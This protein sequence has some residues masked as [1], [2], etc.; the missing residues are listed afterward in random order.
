MT[1]IWTIYLSKYTPGNIDATEFLEAALAR[2]PWEKIFEDVEGRFY[3]HSM[4]FSHCLATTNP[5]TLL[6]KRL[7]IKSFKRLR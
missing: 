2:M 7:L 3:Q 6:N 4:Y 5:E 1:I